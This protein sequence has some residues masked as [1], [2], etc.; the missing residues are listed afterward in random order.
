MGE[1]DVG[2]LM[3]TYIA[4]IIGFTAVPFPIIYIGAN[5]ATNP[6]NRHYSPPEK[7]VWRVMTKGDFASW[8]FWALYMPIYIVV[9]GLTID[10]NSVG[11]IST[12]ESI[13][14][15]IFFILGFFAEHII[16][17]YINK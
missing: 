6:H 3:Q 9:F 12:V 17:R 14:M 15:T 10:Y 7:R 2:R 16:R 4:L 5:L 13:F 1:I 11:T 8:E